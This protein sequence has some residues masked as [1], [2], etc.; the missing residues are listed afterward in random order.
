MGRHRAV[1]PA[2]RDEVHDIVMDVGRRG[3]SVNSMALAC[4]VNKATLFWWV[5][6]HEVFAASFDKARQLAQL[7][8]EELGRANLHNPHFREQVWWLRLQ[9]FPEYRRPNKTVEHKD[10][11]TT[12]IL[13]E[14]VVVTRS[15]SAAE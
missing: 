3:G 10:K 7:H 12:P 6:K 8:W 1:E 9:R 13:I 14:R 4:G 15:A 2:Y 5:K 11:A